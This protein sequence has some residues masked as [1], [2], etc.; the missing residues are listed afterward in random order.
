VVA[1]VPASRTHSSVVSQLRDSHFEAT[2]LRRGYGVAGPPSSKTTAW[3]TGFTRVPPTLSY[4]VTARGGKRAL[5]LQFSVT[6][7]TAS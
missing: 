4:G 3:Q 6:L 2:G 5:P 7:Q 1:A